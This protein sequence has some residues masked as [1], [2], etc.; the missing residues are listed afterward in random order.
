MC[1]AHIS[2]NKDFEVSC[3]QGHRKILPPTR[4]LIA[5]DKNSL[6]AAVHNERKCY[7]DRKNLTVSINR[8]ISCHLL[9]ACFYCFQSTWFT[10]TLPCT[11]SLST[12]LTLVFGLLLVLS[13][14]ALCTE[15]N[16]F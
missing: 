3:S 6:T 11:F 8:L 10:L 12:P 4:K 9:H 7:N 2:H 13:V 5:N 1:S 14:L 16:L 15:S